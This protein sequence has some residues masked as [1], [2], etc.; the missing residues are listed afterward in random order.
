MKTA[1]I[2]QKADMDFGFSRDLGTS[3][4]ARF[5][6]CT[7]KIFKGACDEARIG[8]LRCRRHAD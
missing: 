8:F 7:V 1:A 5:V 6:V 4:S 3:I 2:R